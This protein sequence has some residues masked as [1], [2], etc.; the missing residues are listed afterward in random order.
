MHALFY[1]NDVGL[2]SGLSVADS[3]GPRSTRSLG[4][5][6]T[7][8]GLW[9]DSEESPEEKRSRLRRCLRYSFDV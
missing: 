7:T 2:L 3:M 9:V 8:K 1:V 6:Y 4:E 5:G